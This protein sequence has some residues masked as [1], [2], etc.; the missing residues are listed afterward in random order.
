ML[1]AVVEQMHGGAEMTFGERAG[2]RALIAHEYDGAGSR[3]RQHQRLVAAAIQIREQVAA[4]AHD[5]HTVFDVT[6]SVAAAED[7]WAFS[8]LKE[9]P[10]KVGNERR[11]RAPAHRKIADADDRLAETGRGRCWSSCSGEKQ[12]RPPI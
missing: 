7:G 1:K 6:A 9:Q 10:R 4:V 3:A 12:P 11:L 5:D 8:R 2:D